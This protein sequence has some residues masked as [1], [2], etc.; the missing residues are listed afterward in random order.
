MSRRTVVASVFLLWGVVSG[1][2]F[3]FFGSELIMESKDSGPLS[4]LSEIILIFSIFGQALEHHFR[5]IPA[6]VAFWIG[7]L[8]FYGFLFYGIC[9]FQ[10]RKTRAPREAEDKQD[11]K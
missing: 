1:L 9:R 2:L 6:L 4:L 5:G 3:C 7:Q 11:S 10:P 8:A